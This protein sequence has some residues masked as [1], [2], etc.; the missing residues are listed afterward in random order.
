[1]RGA[2]AEMAVVEEHGGAVK[3]VAYMKAR[4]VESHRERV[5]RIE[6]GEQKVIGQNSFTETE[7]SPL[8]A[9]A[10]GGI[11]TPDPEV[12]RERVEALEQWKADRDESAVQDALTELAAA[13]AGDSVNIMPETI[14]AGKAWPTTGEWTT[15][16]GGAVG[17]YW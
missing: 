5:A 2:G 8:T 9:G 11:L 3:A 10:D 7:D 16:R 14:A 15:A 12:E 1:S 17:D 4:L 13:A 6:A